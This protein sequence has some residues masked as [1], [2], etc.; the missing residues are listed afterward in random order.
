MRNAQGY[1]LIAGG[2]GGP[3]ERTGGATGD[4]VK[5]TGLGPGCD[6]VTRVSRP[7]ATT[8]ISFNTTRDLAE[9]WLRPEHM[10]LS[11][12]GSSVS[13]MQYLRMI[14]WLMELWQM[15]HLSITN[16]LSSQY[17][18][19]RWQKIEVIHE[20]VSEAL[21]QQQRLSQLTIASVTLGPNVPVVTFISRNL[22]PMRGFHTLMRALP[23]LLVVPDSTSSHSGR[24]RSELF[25]RPWRWSELARLHV[26]RDW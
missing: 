26:G 6:V 11:P 19:Q 22:E 21:L 24:R 3:P 23:S 25:K 5:A 17:L 1:I 4:V 20:G 9:L 16:P 12:T 2:D 8:G 18:S 13:Q 7:T 10:G 14:G 15:H